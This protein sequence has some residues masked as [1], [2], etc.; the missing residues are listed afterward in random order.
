MAFAG[1]G[2]LEG[3]FQTKCGFL[4]LDAESWAEGGKVVVINA[5]R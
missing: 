3:A 2:E 4:A 1:L 5:T